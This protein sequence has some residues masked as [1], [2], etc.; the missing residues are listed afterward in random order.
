MAYTR[1]YTEGVGWENEPSINTPISAENL[2]QMDE[3]I[4]D[5]DAAVYTE[6]AAVYAAIAQAGGNS[7]P[8]SDHIVSVDSSSP[9][10]NTSS[11]RIGDFKE[12]EL[13]FLRCDVDAHYDS[14]WSGAW[15]IYAGGSTNIGSIADCRNH[16]L[17]SE[18]FNEDISA[19]SVLV[20]ARYP[21]PWTVWALYAIIPASGGSGAISYYS[22]ATETVDDG[23]I[24]T[25]RS[26]FHGNTPNVG[27]MLFLRVD[28]DAHKTS[29][30]AYP[31]YVVYG[32]AQSSVGDDQIYDCRSAFATIAFWQ[33]IA[34]GST[35]IMSYDGYVWDLRAVIPASGG[36]TT[37]VANPA[38][39]ATDSLNKLQVGSTIYEIPNIDTAWAGKVTAVS[40]AN[41][42]PNNASFQIDPFT[43]SNFVVLDIGVDAVLSGGVTRW[44]LQYTVDGN[45]VTKGISDG[46]NGN[47]YDPNFDDDLVA[48]TTLILQMVGNNFACLAVL[49]GGGASTLSDLTDTE[50]S[51]PSDGQFLKYDATSGKWINAIGDSGAKIAYGVANPTEATGGNGTLYLQAN[52]FSGTYKYLKFEITARKGGGDGL[53]QF[54][55]L[56]FLDTYGQAI[57][58][59]SGITWS[60]NVSTYE[61]DPINQYSKFLGTNLPTITFTF[62][63]NERFDL[64][65]AINY[66]WYTAND[67]PVRDPVS[68]NMYVSNDGINWIL[69]D[70]RSN[71]TITDT[72]DTVAFTSDGYNKLPTGISIKNVYY[73]DNDNWIKDDFGGGSSTLAGLTDTAITTP[74]NG[75]VLTYDA[76]NDK[77]I[78]AASGSGGVAASVIGPEE[79]GATASQAY[80]VGDHFIRNDKFC[81][82]SASIASGATLTKDTNYTE[83]DVAS[84]LSS[85]GGGVN[86][87]DYAVASPATANMRETLWAAFAASG[88]SKL[89]RVDIVTDAGTNNENSKCFN[90][91]QQNAS[92]FIITMTTLYDY[93]DSYSN[94]KEETFLL[95]AS[96]SG[97]N[98]NVCKR[99]GAGDS[100]GTGVRE[101]YNAM[102]PGSAYS[103]MTIRIWGV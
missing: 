41:I 99:N 8:M 73:N 43:A 95:R 20:L 24:Y 9:K 70:A 84:A 14:G 98:I 100:L 21:A 7:R 4:Q 63:D 31:W 37:V 86:Y 88:F 18:Y 97:L 5:V 3:A 62:P 32:T 103:T 71:E 34:A 60:S 58:W 90:I 6:F 46:R 11:T 50:I 2:N 66:C 47:A 35:L 1:Q 17:D 69:I 29:G 28:V 75:Q 85:G 51:T 23:N 15:S 67:Q 55:R 33:D 42:T 49:G 44:S 61:N 82:A 13:F 57:A 48:G 89:A 40:G 26:I 19:G 72:R 79:T 81:T 45:T 92:S 59:P 16:Y 56:T 102:F 52:P 94:I 83:G 22:D 91:F 53:T 65:T 38:G 54:S 27:D 10:L 39:T 76:A 12:W 93:W 64:S 87:Y 77:W 80:A 96:N 68:W 101:G 74:T 25:D 78:N 30:T 36:G